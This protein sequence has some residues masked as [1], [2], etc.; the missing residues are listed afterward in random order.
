MIYKYTN[1]Y[2]FFFT[3]T[4]QEKKSDLVDFPGWIVAGN[5]LRTDIFLS[6]CEPRRIFWN[7]YVKVCFTRQAVDWNTEFNLNG[8]RIWPWTEKIHYNIVETFKPDLPCS[9][10]YCT[11]LRL[12]LSNDTNDTNNS[13]NNWVLVTFYNR[14]Y[15]YGYQCF[16]PWNTHTHSHLLKH[17]Q[18]NLNASFTLLGSDQR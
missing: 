17:T 12:V 3:R 8:S 7:N 13:H 16:W 18:Y 6:W 1:I 5:E 15:L 4:P 14:N 11:M 9:V 2:I 10:Y